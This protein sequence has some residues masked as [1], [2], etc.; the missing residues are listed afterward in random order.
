MAEQLVT[1][2]AEFQPLHPLRRAASD[3]CRELLGDLERIFRRCQGD[4]RAQQ[5]GA[6]NALR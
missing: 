6:A 4:R 1:S 2:N 3:S 5:L